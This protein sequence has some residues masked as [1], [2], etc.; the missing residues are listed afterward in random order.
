M[1]A[2][3]LL[4]YLG[5]SVA[6]LVLNGCADFI[7]NAPD[8]QLTLEM[9]FNDK[10]RTEDWLANIYSKIPDPY[11]GYANKIGWEIAGDDMTA[12]QRWQQWWTG[13]LL[14]FR[15]GSFYTNSDWDAKYWN[16][17]PQRI[18]SAYIL[19]NNAHANP[20]QKVTEEDIELM[21][22]ECRFLIA[23]YYWT[24]TETYGAVPYFDD[25]VDVN[26]PLDEMAVGQM[27]F[28]DMVD[29]LD[30][31]LLDLSDKLPAEWEE[32]FFGRATSI[33][34]LAVRDRKS[35]V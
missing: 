35:V 29:M 33:A 25:V 2:I 13:S 20:L 5:V 31:Q 1:K 7:D 14:K 32:A 10:T 22:N 26:A 16:E 6:C 3:N 30:K 12:S 11:W 18:R 19:I 27:A 8:D 21:R 15:V 34:C 9:V 17:L 4:K 24:L 28:D 23:Y